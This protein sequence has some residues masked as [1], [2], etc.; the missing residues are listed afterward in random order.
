VPE[1]LESFESWLLRRVAQAVET[2]EVSGDLRS[3]L[4]AECEGS[5][6]TP[7][8]QSHAEAVQDIAVEL[9]MPLETV[10]AGL[11]ALEAQPRVIR[12]VLMH[13][14]AEAWLEGHGKAHYNG[15]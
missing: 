12:E 7:V 8:A 10:E 4:R 5:R 15:E 2:G 11:T 3:E 14:I 13:R 9:H 1:P 6:A